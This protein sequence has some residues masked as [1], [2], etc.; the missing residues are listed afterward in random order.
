MCDCSVYRS[1]CIECCSLGS[2]SDL[3]LQFCLSVFCMNRYVVSVQLFVFHNDDFEL[4]FYELKE[5][6]PTFEP[7]YQKKRGKKNKCPHNTYKIHYFYMFICV[8][9]DAAHSLACTPIHPGER[10]I[11][12]VCVKMNTVSRLLHIYI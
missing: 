3:F 2:L 6:H 9:Y 1:P 12:I 7:I 5:K 8:A 4:Q 10:G 11:E